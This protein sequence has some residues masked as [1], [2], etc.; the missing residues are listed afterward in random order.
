MF[1]IAIID[2]EK[3][4]LHFL[5]KLFEI[6]NFKVFDFCSGL[7]GLEFLK[8]NRVDS[9]LLDVRMPDI[10]GEEVL[11]HIKILDKNL[12]VIIMTAYGDIDGAVEFIKQGA[13]D[14]VTKP[15]PKEKILE[16]VKNSCEKYNLLKE[17]IRLKK[18]LFSYPF[19]PSDIICESRE[20]TDILMLAKNVAPTDTTVLLQGESGTGKELIAKLIHYHSNRAD[21]IFF[22]VN[23]STFSETLFESHLFGHIKGAFTGAIKEHKGILSEIDGGVLFLDEIT[24]ISL[25]IQSKLL[26]LVQNKEF[27]P[28]GSHRVKFSD[29][30]IIAATN[31]NLQD[32]VEKGSFRKDLFYRLNVI[33]VNIPPLR[34][35]KE[36]IKPLVLYFIKKFSI[37]FN[38]IVRGIEQKALDALESYDFPGNVRELE[39]LIERAVILTNKE[40]LGMEAFPDN[41]SEKHFFEINQ[42]GILPL[43]EV[44][45]NYIRRVY[46]MTGKNKLQTA[47]LLKVSR[48]TIA[49]KLKETD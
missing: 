7:E 3:G 13:Y 24:E 41:I 23:C 33:T 39:N 44:I 10:S 36:D 31:K 37:K 6:K 18:E 2:D 32:E 29:I 8:K 12:P 47:N 45:N 42:E 40:T 4:M 19:S 22:P 46:L 43:D 5:K 26:R 11:K 1:K 38:K 9:V 49:R 15:F 20:M 14:Y 27:I 21:K 30:R 17:N 48:K 25:Q 28:V 35:R 16:V 34:K